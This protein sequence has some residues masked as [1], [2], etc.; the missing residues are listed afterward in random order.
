MEEEKVDDAKE[1]GQMLTKLVTGFALAT[2]WWLCV[3]RSVWAASHPSVATIVCFACLPLGWALADIKLVLSNLRDIKGRTERLLTSGMW[4]SLGLSWMG[5]FIAIA[6]L[7]ARAHDHPSITRSGAIDYLRETA[8][9]GAI[10]FAVVWLGISLNVLLGNKITQDE[11]DHHWT[12]SERLRVLCFAY[13]AALVTMSVLLARLVWA[14][15]GWCLVKLAPLKL[16]E[17][18]RR[19]LSG[20]WRV[21]CWFARGTRACFV[22][23]TLWSVSLSVRLLGWVFYPLPSRVSIIIC[24]SAV[25]VGL[26]HAYGIRH[27]SY[28][29][30]TGLMILLVLQVL[31]GEFWRKR[32]S[33]YADRIDAYPA[34]KPSK[35]AES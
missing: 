33:A 18:V 7:N 8:K 35:T 21:L 27:W 11:H 5:C 23:L 26:Y 16:T 19:L 14:V 22:G 25:I 24:M 15:L 29:V 20:A 28:I 2:V 30:W 34:I 6:D 12:N 32:L 1:L 10:G 4:M 31:P 3:R 17:L 9:L 13:P